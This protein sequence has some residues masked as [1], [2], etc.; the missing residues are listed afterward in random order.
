MADGLTVDMRS[1]DDT[2]KWLSPLSVTMNR[3]VVDKG[4][5][6]CCFFPACVLRFSRGTVSSTVHP[7]CG[8][9]DGRGILVI[10]FI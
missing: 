7:S 9:V 6:F 8:L 3:R 4:F 10:G 1:N 5:H 2:M